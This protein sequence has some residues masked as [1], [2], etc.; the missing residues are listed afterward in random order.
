[1]YKHFEVEGRM[2]ISTTGR[3][4][5]HNFGNGKIWSLKHSIASSIAP[6]N[7]AH[8]F[9]R[10]ITTVVLPSLSPTM[11]AGVV[12]EWKKKPGD[13][14]SPGDILCEVTTDKASVGFEVFKVLLE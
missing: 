6:R 12:A 3:R 13:V 2:S 14:L 4:F 5:V 8:I 7:C 1:M 10:S 9:S 11:T